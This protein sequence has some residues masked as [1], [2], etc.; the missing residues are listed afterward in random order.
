VRRNGGR[1]MD[2]IDILREELKTLFLATTSNAV[3]Y[4]LVAGSLYLLFYKTRLF[5]GRSLRPENG[6]VKI[7]QTRGEIGLSLSSC[8]I[9]S[10][11]AVGV[12]LLNPLGITRIYFSHDTFGYGYAA[13]SLVAAVF[14]FDAYFYF[15]H[16]ILH[17]LGVK[18]STHHMHHASVYPTPWAALAF[19][20]PEA[21]IIGAFFFIITI[22]LP[23]HMDVYIAFLWIVFIQSALHHS[24]Y[25]VYSESWSRWPVT[26]HWT[27]VRHHHLHHRSGRYNFGLY[28][29]WWD[30]WLGTEHP[31]YHLQTAAAGPHTDVRTDRAAPDPN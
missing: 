30:R 11:A 24:S 12:H 14:L 8:V 23:I 31:D 9:F 29:T 5:Q 4:F 13:I 16:R 22:I 15:S 28:F 20:I 21:M 25:E 1:W 26:R 19:S 7:G 3:R 27:T 6:T 10:F 2:L 18:R 17:V